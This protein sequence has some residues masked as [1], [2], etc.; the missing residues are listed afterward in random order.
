LNN[1]CIV[2]ISACWSVT[3][4]VAKALTSAFAVVVSTCCRHGDGAAV[5]LDHHGQPLPVEV[6]HF[7]L[8]E[9]RQVGVAHHSV[10]AAVVRPGRPRRLR[11]PHSEPPLHQLDLGILSLLGNC[12]Q[13]LTSVE[14]DAFDWASSAISTA[15]S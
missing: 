7:G 10:A 6:R 15:C 11:A 3:T 13:V 4:A 2:V 5:M 14:A 8:P 1:C 9:R 12:G